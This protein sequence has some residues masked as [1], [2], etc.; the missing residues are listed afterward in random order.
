MKISK[1]TIGDLVIED[2]RVA[3]LLESYNIDFYY[4]GN[5]PLDEVLERE[6]VSKTKLFEEI[7]DLQKNTLTEGI[8]YNVWP[9]ELFTNY[10]EQTHHKYIKQKTPVILKYL[11][12]I[13]KIHGRFHPE[14]LQIKQL[15][16]QSS[17]ELAAKMKMEELIVFPA[18]RNAASR[19]MNLIFS[20][21]SKYE[22]IQNLIQIMNEK[23]KDEGRLFKVITELSNYYHPPVDA[24]NTFIITYSL[25]KEFDADLHLHVHLENNILFPKIIIMDQE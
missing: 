14:L 25:L 23:H 9:I 20:Q 11:Q 19:S 5:L 4:N 3:T 22:T 17:R 10:I 8:N 18:I 13:C 1:K 16:E 15:F 12:K 2:S 6:G 21:G 24:C 7:N